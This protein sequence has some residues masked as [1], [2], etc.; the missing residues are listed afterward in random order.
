MKYESVI[1]LP[2]MLMYQN[3]RGMTGLRARRL[4]TNC[5]SQRAPNI[6][7]PTQPTSFH[8]VMWM[9][10]QASQASGVCMKPVS[11]AACSMASAGDIT[12][13]RCRCGGCG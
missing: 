13:P 11:D 9:P 7:A 2:T 4:A 3:R 10:L 1:R 8:G 6:S 12:A 5:T